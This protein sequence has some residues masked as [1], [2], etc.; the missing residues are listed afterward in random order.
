MLLTSMVRYVNNFLIVNL[1]S[2][3]DINTSSISSFFLQ[4]RD[5]NILSWLIN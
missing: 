2:L 5:I 1:V 3:W 4:L